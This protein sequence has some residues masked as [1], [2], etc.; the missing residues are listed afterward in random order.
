VTLKA[1]DPKGLSNTASLEILVGNE[2]PVVD[3]AVEGNK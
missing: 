3:I 1:A 2:A